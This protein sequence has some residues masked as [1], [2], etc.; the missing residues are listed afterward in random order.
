M[1]TYVARGAQLVVYASSSYDSSNSYNGDD[2]RHCHHGRNE[3][4]GHCREDSQE[5][6]R[7]EAVLSTS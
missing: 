2:A 1:V 7:L 4:L 6:E 3:A 5:T